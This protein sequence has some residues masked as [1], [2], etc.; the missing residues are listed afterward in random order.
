MND[1]TTLEIKLTAVHVSDQDRA[2]RFYTEVL[3]LA[4]KADISRG[5]FR[6]LTVTSPAAPDGAELQLALATDDAA[7]TYQAARRERHEPALLLFTRDLAGEHA[8]L[9]ARGATFTMPPTEVP[10][11]TIAVVDDTCG[12]LVQLVQLHRHG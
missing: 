11:S 5:P 4:K 12:N 8:R 6:W 10:G 1:A 2:L 3:G 9:T 7:R